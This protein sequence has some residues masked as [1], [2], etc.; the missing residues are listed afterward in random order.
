MS[1][2]RFAIVLGFAASLA[3]SGCAVGPDFK[4]PAAPAGAGY[5]PTLL[6]EVSVS[7]PVEGGAAQHLLPGQDVQF[8]WWTA[9]QCPQINSLVERAL[10]RNPT[11][12]SAK[13]ALAQAQELVYAQQGFFFPTISAG[14]SF[15]RQKLAGNLSG[16]SAPGVQGN[17]SA[18]LATQNANP[19]PPPHNKPLFFNFH[20]AT[21]TVSYDPDVFGGN[22]RQVESLDAQTAVQRFEMEAA[23][24]TLVSNVVAA[25]IQEAETQ[26]QIAATQEII[27]INTKSLEILRNQQRFG[28]AMAIDVDP[29]RGAVSK[30]S[31]RRLSECRGYASCLVL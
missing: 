20:T 3:A 22:R 13:A 18:I 16:S 17:G 8:D 5:S 9:F 23:Y 11:I 2:M 7:A 28:Q 30:H 12:A 15:E 21:L 31:H 27:D 24:I 1:G 29:I 14:Y 25:A 6:S 26:A 19:Q 10:Q 4:R